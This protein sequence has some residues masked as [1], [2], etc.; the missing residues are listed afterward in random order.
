[1][2]TGWSPFAIALDGTLSYLTVRDFPDGGGVEFGA[3]AYGDR[4]EQATAT[5]IR[6]LHAWDARGRNL[7]EDSFA[8]WPDGAS[9]HQPGRLV[10]ALRKR[11]GTVTITWPP[12]RTASQTAS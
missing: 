11:H 2:K 10:T 5:L 8:Y 1:M 3:Y 9:P 6:H 4:A 12:E 7:P